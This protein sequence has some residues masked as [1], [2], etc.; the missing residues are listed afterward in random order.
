MMTPTQVLKLTRTL[1]SNRERLGLT[2][3]EVARRAHVNIGTV[4]RIEHGQITNPRTENLLAI[5]AVLEIPAADVFTMTNL[6]Q[7]NDLPTF[8]PYLRAKY[9]HLPESAIAEMQRVFD[10]I[11]SR[12]G[13]KG[14]NPGEDE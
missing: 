12:V 10:D 6:L 5:A 14:P 13:H 3:A 7:A 11:A 9:Q 4:T 1:K 2:A 8:T